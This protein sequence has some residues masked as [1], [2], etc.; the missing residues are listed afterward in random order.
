MAPMH[1]QNLLDKIL[2]CA[3]LNALPKF[4]TVSLTRIYFS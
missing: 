3:D 2:E 4:S 1:V